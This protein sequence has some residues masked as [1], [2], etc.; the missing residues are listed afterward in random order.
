[1]P[2]NQVT[3][4]ELRARKKRPSNAGKNSSGNVTIANAGLLP[5]EL[6]WDVLK[7]YPQELVAELRERVAAECPKLREKINRSSRYLGYSNGGSDAAYL[8]VRKNDLLIDMRVSA[9]LFEDLTLLGFKVR[10]RDNF[11]A[12]SGWLT[13]LIVPYDTDKVATVA[14]LLIE[15]LSGV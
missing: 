2:D 4:R 5:D 12:K 9:E 8:Y 13:G 6:L 7:G 14:K 11:Q 3:Q 15:A 1:M 10:P